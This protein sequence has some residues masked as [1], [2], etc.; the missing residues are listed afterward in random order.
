M[1]SRGRERFVDPN[2]DTKTVTAYCAAETYDIQAAA[3][4]VQNQGYELDP[5]Q[6]GLYPQ[7][8]HIQ[9]SDRP[10]EVKDFQQGDIFIFSSGTVVTLECP[11]KRSLET[12]QPSSPLRS[13]R[14]ASKFA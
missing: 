14:I 4:L 8:V 1:K 6:T 12:S 13:R 7:V 10:S 11:R 9:T 5:F 2:I 3:K